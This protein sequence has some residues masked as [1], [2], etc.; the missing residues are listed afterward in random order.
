M[1]E[2]TALTTER[3]LEHEGIP[4]VRL[5]AVTPVVSGGGK[6]PARRINAFY[7][8]IADAVEKQIKKSMLKRAAADFNEALA[9]SCPFEPYRVKMT[10]DTVQTDGGL[11]V[12]RRLYTR[13]GGGAEH[14]RILTENWNTAL[15]L[16]EKL[17]AKDVNYSSPSDMIEISNAV[18]SSAPSSVTFM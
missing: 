9:K 17:R 13:T 12:R 8:H 18:R 7:G 16:P 11:E 14:E 15:G 3:V 1:F 6:R 10:F 2:I 5:T 4:V